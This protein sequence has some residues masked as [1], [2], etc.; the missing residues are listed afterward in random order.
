MRTP[1]GAQ[2]E[3]VRRTQEVAGDWL[4]HLQRHRELA[5]DARE[6]S[7]CIAPGYLVGQLTCRGGGASEGA[8]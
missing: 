6:T 4:A 7:G 5:F 8:W 2:R 3:A 1:P